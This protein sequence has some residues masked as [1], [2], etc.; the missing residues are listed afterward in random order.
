MAARPGQPCRVVARTACRITFV[1]TPGSEAMERCGAFTSVMWACAFS[2]MASCSV[3]GMAWSAAPTT[4]HD[5]IVYQAGTP[6]GSARALVA[7][8]SWVTASTCASVASRPSAM[9]GGNALWV[10]YAV[11]WSSR[12]RPRA[13]SGG[14][15]AG[16]GWP[17]SGCA[18]RVR[19]CATVRAGSHRPVTRSEGVLA[20]ARMRTMTGLPLSVCCGRWCRRAARRSRSRSITSEAASSLFGS[21]R[22]QLYPLFYADRS[23]GCPARDRASRDLR[24]Q[25]GGGSFEV[26]FR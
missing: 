11:S 26:R 14:W 22:P 2:A 16:G 17:A 9:H 20:A 3:G 23:R 8:G 13:G 5:G 6:D 18:G 7:M 19:G 12:S 25:S 15:A 24:E 1:T 21:G 4:A 10:M